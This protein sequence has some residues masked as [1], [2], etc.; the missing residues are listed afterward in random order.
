M[1]ARTFVGGPGLHAIVFGSPVPVEPPPR[2][3]T[4]RAP[5]ARVTR[6]YSWS[7]FFIG[8]APCGRL[9]ACCK[10]RT[11]VA[12][13]GARGPCGTVRTATRMRPTV[14]DIAWPETRHETTQRQLRLR[15]ARRAA[16]RRRFYGVLMG[17]RPRRR[18]FGE[19]SGPPL[20]RPPLFEP[21]FPPPS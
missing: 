8:H 19:A 6:E 18:Q 13:G 11:L 4:G 16:G 15:V 3:R 10:Y 1:E 2:V 9:R 20:P 14:R 12:S 5:I 7:Y 17:R 21:R